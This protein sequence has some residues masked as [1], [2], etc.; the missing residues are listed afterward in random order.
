MELNKAIEIVE[1][2][3]KEAGKKM[4][5]DCLAALKLENEAAKRIV[6]ARWGYTHEIIAPLP[7]ED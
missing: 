4:P 2:N 1:L 7:G 6:D 5:P 3:I